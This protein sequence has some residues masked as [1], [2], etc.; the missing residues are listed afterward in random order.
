MA[1]NQDEPAAPVA[2]SWPGLP[3]AWNRAPMNFLRRLFHRH[4]WAVLSGSIDRLTITA[5]AC[6]CGANKQIT[7]KGE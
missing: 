7:T 2:R 6:W 5:H 4:R 3:L 1:V